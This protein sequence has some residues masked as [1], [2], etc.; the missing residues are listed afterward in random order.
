MLNDEEKVAGP[1]TLERH[2]GRP[3]DA[4]RD[5]ALRGAALK[6]LAEQGYDR[7]TVD[8]I[9]AE[10]CA[11]K[12]TIYRRWSNKAE[13]VIDAIACKKAELEAPD[14]GSL[15]GDLDA[16]VEQTA[17]GEIPVDAPVMIGLVS[18]LPHD[19]ELRAVVQ[20]RLITPQV[21]VLTTVLERAKRRGEIAA[22]ADLALITSV[23]PAMVMYRML[24][25]PMPVERGFFREVLNTIVLP[26]LRAGQPLDLDAPP[27]K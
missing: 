12:A 11:S 27:T 16:L 22:S 26:A 9:A 20:E 6:L 13:L 25:N 5:E 18:A 4:T 1:E 7:L 23:V 17:T 3:L 10:A 24:L 2:V 14:T 21:R 8:G 15:E 19:A